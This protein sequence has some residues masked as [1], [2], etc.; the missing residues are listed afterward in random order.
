MI[1][2]SLEYG[3]RTHCS[4]Q[5]DRVFINCSDS[6]VQRST[7]SRTHLKEGPLRGSSFV[8]RTFIRRNSCIDRPRGC[9]HCG[10]ENNV[11][12]L[13]LS[14]FINPWNKK[15]VAGGSA[16]QPS[17]VEERSFPY[18]L[19]A[20]WTHLIIELCG[21]FGLR[22]TKSLS[23]F[24]WHARTVHD[25]ANIFP[26]L[27]T[28]L[29]E[30]PPPTSVWYL[31][32]YS[33]YRLGKVSKYD[34]RG[35]KCK[36]SAFR[37]IPLFHKLIWASTWSPRKLQSQPSHRPN[38]QNVFERLNVL[39]PSLER[40]KHIR[41]DIKEGLVQLWEMMGFS[42]VCLSQVRSWAIAEHTPMDLFFPPL[43][44]GLPAACANGFC[45]TGIPLDFKSSQLQSKSSIC[46]QL[47]NFL[48]TSS[49]DGQGHNPFPLICRSIHKAN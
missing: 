4:S 2:L 49:K 40:L 5:E 31:T 41:N 39:D 13:D 45:T 24:G 14:T 46:L 11:D 30:E 27:G 26:V 9:S 21:T 8:I 23:K 20:R 12:P 17:Q 7:T 43:W 28:I 47:V 6:A 44:S 48:K 16:Q 35:S 18:A 38:G 36:H 29:P 19:T 1:L 33:P 34:A 10:V 42:S 25:L 15:H 32:D 3:Q 22:P 37:L